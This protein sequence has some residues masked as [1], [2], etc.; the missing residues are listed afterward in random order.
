MRTAVLLPFI[1]LGLATAAAAAPPK[2]LNSSPADAA[3]GEPPHAIRLTFDQAVLSESPQF[4]LRM[5]SMPGMAMN[6]PAS[7]TINAVNHD[8][9]EKL[10]LGLAT[11][12]VPGRYELAW[13]VANTAGETTKGVIHFG[14]R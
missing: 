1:A 11:P 12:L 7:V 2:L 3:I 10:D 14:V 5:V 8:G 6:Q 13:S 9:P 4:A